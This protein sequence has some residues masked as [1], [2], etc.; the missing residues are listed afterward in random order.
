[1]SNS[2]SNASKFAIDKAQS[3]VLNFRQKFGEGHYW[4]ACHA[5]FPLAL[6]SELLYTLRA[7]FLFDNHGSPLRSPWIAVADTL[8]NLCKETGHELYQMDPA[9][10]EILLRELKNNKRFQKGSFRIDRLQQL[11]HFLLAYVEQHL[12][13]SDESLQTFAEAQSWAAL[14]YIN[15]QEAT[16]KIAQAI[17]EAQN[18]ENDH[19]QVRLQLLLDNLLEEHPELN[20]LRQYAQANVASLGGNPV[21]AQDFNATV[22]SSDKIEIAGV[23]LNN[24]VPEEIPSPHQLQIEILQQGLKTLDFYKG[25]LT[26]KMDD[27]TTAAVEAF[28]E[29]QQ[30]D[31]SGKS[32]TFLLREVE[33]AIDQQRGKKVTDIK[34]KVYLSN[35]NQLRYAKNF[36]FLYD[37]LLDKLKELETKGLIELDYYTKHTSDS[38]TN[39]DAIDRSRDEAELTLMPIN[40]D[41]IKGGLRNR[42]NIADFYEDKMVN[43]TTLVVPIVLEDL[44]EYKKDFSNFPQLPADGVPLVDGRSV[45]GQSDDVHLETMLHDIETLVDRLTHLKRSDAEGK[46]VFEQ[47][48]YDF[49]FDASGGEDLNIYLS[50]TN[51]DRTMMEEIVSEFR[52]IGNYNFIDPEKELEGIDHRDIAEEREA[53]LK[54]SDL[55]LAFLSPDYLA[56]SLHVS[57]EFRQAMQQEKDTDL[58]MVSILL[59]PCLTEWSL[60][61]SIGRIPTSGIPFSD[62]KD[63]PLFDARI[64]DFTQQMLEAKVR[65][66]NKEKGEDF[67]NLQVFNDP[68][69][70]TFP[71][72]DLG[73]LPKTLL[74]R[75]HPD[76]RA[77]FDRFVTH[78]DSL[79]GY[80][81]FN[82]DQQE[83]GISKI[84]PHT[85]QSYAIDRSDVIINLISPAF[86][87]HAPFMDSIP[88]ILGNVQ[89]GSKQAFNIILG[90]SFEQK[91]PLME[92]PLL[93]ETQIEK[94]DN[95]LGWVEVSRALIE[96]LSQVNEDKQMDF[97][98]LSVEELIQLCLEEE[99]EVLDLSNR[100]LSEIPENVAQLS[101]LKR[102]NFSSNNL[103]TLPTFLFSSLPNI[104]KAKLA[105]NQLEEIPEEISN[106][107]NL[108]EINVSNNL[109]QRLPIELNLIEPLPTL[110]VSNNPLPIYSKVIHD[111]PEDLF[112]MILINQDF[113][114]NKSREDKIQLQRALAK[115]QEVNT[116]GEFNEAFFRALYIWQEENKLKPGAL[117]EDTIRALFPSDNFIK[118]DDPN[119]QQQ[120]Q[121][122]SSVEVPDPVNNLA[123]EILELI[124]ANKI[125]KAIQLLLERN[126]PYVKKQAILYAAR[127]ALLK[128]QIVRGLISEQN[129]LNHENE[130]TSDLLRLVMEFEKEKILENPQKNYPSKLPPR[131]EE[132]IT[133]INTLIQK[134]KLKQALDQTQS[135]MLGINIAKDLENA[136]IQLNL[137]NKIL[138]EDYNSKGVITFKY[139]SENIDQ[140]NEELLTILEKIRT[141]IESGNFSDADFIERTSPDIK[142]AGRKQTSKSKFKPQ[143]KTE[144]EAEAKERNNDVKKIIAQG[145]IKEALQQ[146]R[147]NQKRY[148]TAENHL[149]ALISLSARLT[150]VQER[151]TQDL[152]SPE[153]FNIER[154]KITLSLLNTL[155]EIENH[156]PS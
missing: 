116:N 34:L 26:G 82:I 103:K 18:T 56:S 17:A 115:Y 131:A 20:R 85:E 122:A 4:L 94:A 50:Y 112:E 117:D 130:L 156:S 57:I 71:I 150:R 63:R 132:R 13:S 135:L 139:F 104:T 121:T 42:K 137:K 14:T 134:G 141:T 33:E 11:G 48:D 92:L 124:G 8:L 15:P 126:D 43:R 84:D 75:Y 152:I 120:S 64:L 80:K 90:G 72:G 108:E 65:K 88:Q 67:W 6:T 127:F 16:Q 23:S 41:L 109:L 54:K 24:L 147:E 148:P 93:R 149:L 125:D 145:K 38:F 53:L 32:L 2:N 68:N 69:P 10:R 78:L 77:Y 113:V 29:D 61:R 151:Q 30:V 51:P 111:H 154:N 83:F 99:L 12:Y 66:K 22:S 44:G 40:P 74:I 87:E 138:S 5:A 107:Q 128:E 110:R 106:W 9:V 60:T 142:S 133:K 89:S 144:S 1:M 146:A 91:T 25:E 21:P 153:D 58:K 35:S 96:A 45:T 143:S 97:R 86:L 155:D 39:K 46:L 36:R 3:L 76:N 73:K 105:D 136:L 129:K 119:I 19:E 70:S 79:S 102:L 114:K 81:V 52:D 27:L 31:G 62:L 7:N 55:V 98:A 118:V 49:L 37:P 47:S 59:R 101:H 28:L 100:K 140:I 95:D 123:E